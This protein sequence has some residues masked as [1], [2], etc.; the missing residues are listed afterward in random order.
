[1][2]EFFIALGLNLFDLGPPSTEKS[3]RV[4]AAFALVLALALVITAVALG[5]LGLLADDSGVR[6]VYLIIAVCCLL[7]SAM[8]WYSARRMVLDSRRL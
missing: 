2:S 4:R 8:F 5:V 3:A 6:K 7:Q 1:M